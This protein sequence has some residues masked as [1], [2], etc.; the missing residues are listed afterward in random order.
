MSVERH[1]DLSQI[2]QATADVTALEA[3]LKT[4]EVLIALS[5]GRLFG[6]AVLECAR[7]AKGVVSTSFHHRLRR[8]PAAHLKALAAKFNTRE[9]LLGKPLTDYSYLKRAAERF[10]PFAGFWRASV[11]WRTSQKAWMHGIWQVQAAAQQ[12]RSLGQQLH[13]AD[14]QRV[15]LL[16]LA[17]R[18]EWHPATRIMQPPFLLA[19]PLWMHPINVSVARCLPQELDGDGVEKEVNNVFKVSSGDAVL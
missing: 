13:D 9:A 3:R 18:S 6:A 16:Q 19:L 4:A 12:C 11:G 1:D 8:Y 2:D 17:C 14:F 5:P 10:E 15:N 7:V